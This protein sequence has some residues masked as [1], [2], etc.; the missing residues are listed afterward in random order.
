MSTAAAAVKLSL[1]GK[2]AAARAAKTAAA[3]KAAAA[4]PLTP[5]AKPP[6]KY[7]LKQ[8]PKAPASASRKSSRIAAATAAARKITG[9]EEENDEEEN[10]EEENGEETE[11]NEVE[12]LA[13]PG[14]GVSIT[15]SPT[16][17]ARAARA[18]ATTR[19]PAAAAPSSPTAAARA[20][21]AAATMRKPPAA[22]AAPSS[23]SAAAAA[24]PLETP[25]RAAPALNA[26]PA[27]PGPRAAAAAAE[28]VAESLV[29]EAAAAEDDKLEIFEKREDYYKYV[30]SRLGLGKKGAELFALLM[31][32]DS[33]HDFKGP[34]AQDNEYMKDGRKTS[35]CMDALAALFRSLIKDVYKSTTPLPEGTQSPTTSKDH[36]QVQNALR[37][38]YNINWSNFENQV[39]IY[40]EKD[41]LNTTLFG[42]PEG[43]I[44]TSVTYS[45]F[46]K[47]IP[48][49]S[50]VLLL[51]EDDKFK[52]SPPKDR[53]TNNATVGKSLLKWFF[54]KRDKSGDAVNKD[55]NMIN[56]KNSFAIGFSFDARTSV[57]KDL[58]RPL[59]DLS[60]I[61]VYQYITPQNFLDS[62]NTNME[63]LTFNDNP[64]FLGGDGTSRNKFMPSLKNEYNNFFTQGQANFSIA[65][66]GFEDDDTKYGWTSIVSESPV[67]LEVLYKDRKDNDKH[68]NG[69]SVK[70]L[71]KLLI[72]CN[73]ETNAAKRNN[74][75]KA[76]SQLDK[77][78]TMVDP[79]P[80]LQRFTDKQDLNKVIFDLKRFGD[81]EQANAVLYLNMKGIPTVFVT[82]DILSGVY[83]RIIGNPTIY[84]NPTSAGA[85]DEEDDDVD[86]GGERSMYCYRGIQ[87]DSDPL[88]AAQGQ[89]TAVINTINSILTKYT[90][91][92]NLTGGK[93]NLD[94][95]IKNIEEFYDKFKF[96]DSDEKV[97]KLYET[98]F[99]YK[100]KNI[101]YYVGKLKATF[102]KLYSVFVEGVH[103]IYTDETI[104]PPITGA[105]KVPE[106][107]REEFDIMYP[108]ETK[109]Q[110]DARFADKTQNK[111]IKKRVHDKA[112]LVNKGISLKADNFPSVESA[113]EFAN[114]LNEK[115]EVINTEIEDA[116]NFIQFFDIVTTTK[117][118]MVDGEKKIEMKV[119]VPDKLF[120]NA[121]S[122][123]DKC[124]LIQFDKSHITEPVRRAKGFDKDGDKRALQKTLKSDDLEGDILIFFEPLIQ[125]LF[126]LNNIMTKAE[127]TAAGGDAGKSTSDELMEK[128]ETLLNKR[129]TSTNDP[130]DKFIEL[131]S[132]LFEEE[133]TKVPLLA[134]GAMYG[135][136]RVDFEDPKESPIAKVFNTVVTAVLD[137]AAEVREMGTDAPT[138][139][140]IPEGIDVD[141]EEEEEEET[142]SPEPTT[143]A[144][145]E[146]VTSETLP[147]VV[148]PVTPETLP[149]GV[150]E[151]NTPERT[152][153]SVNI[154]P[155]SI[156]FGSQE[157]LNAIMKRVKEAAK[158]AKAAAA[159]PV[160]GITTNEKGQPVQQAESRG[161]MFPASQASAPA[162][163]AAGGAII[164]Q[165]GRGGDKYFS[166]YDDV[167]QLEMVKNVIANM[168]GFYKVYGEI[169]PPDT[170][171]DYEFTTESEG[172]KAAV[173]RLPADADAAAKEAARKAYLNGELKTTSAYVKRQIQLLEAAFEERESPDLTIGGYDIRMTNWWR[174]FIA[175]PFNIDA[176][177]ICAI[178]EFKRIMNEKSSGIGGGLSLDPA[179]QKAEVL[180]HFNEAATRHYTKVAINSRLEDISAILLC[181]YENY[182][183]VTATSSYKLLPDSNEA[184]VKIRKLLL[185]EIFLMKQIVEQ[186]DQYNSLVSH[187]EEEAAYKAE[188]DAV[189]LTIE[190][191]KEKFELFDQTKISEAASS[192]PAGTTNPIN[193]Y[194]ADKFMEIYSL[195]DSA[196]GKKRFIIS[197][198]AP[199]TADEM[200]VCGSAAAANAT[201]GGRR[202]THKITRT[203]RRKTHKRRA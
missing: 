13:A 61:H 36:K 18:A 125:N 169:A 1:T 59:N 159:N 51:S 128:L 120:K 83:S 4:V 27:S 119:D 106:Y 48:F 180:A 172:E 21:R 123:V 163:A 110:R 63:V 113:T 23:P 143:A 73:Q 69:P 7:T 158:A 122:I 100:I 76:V 200:A 179:T 70:F 149:T 40:L 15:K 98:I 124:K 155:K 81:H 94:N 137:T 78:Y 95:L 196:A 133:L 2:R 77:N 139:T 57:I 46:A 92:S 8:G 114:K 129:R 194:F 33:Y 99:Q 203:H 52:S 166:N 178:D 85:D 192:A 151:Q 87:F 189:Y 134:G 64:N 167:H 130:K 103:K 148:E 104:N 29:L 145:E 26:F 35:F 135:G 97:K 126:N 109:A 43:T 12:V 132:P 17:A 80:V 84:V 142:V 118:I 71:S 89:V 39:R 37:L 62:A 191:L 140:L 65:N 111:E 68:R 54:E 20:A 38:F 25:P 72:D 53:T 136:E 11:E 175:A 50:H 16:A 138:F 66:D 56:G 170:T 162:A 183:V 150:D 141:E 79:S 193:K 160:F 49:N 105:T 108:D 91:L 164:R 32:C 146:P 47:G 93:T 186:I 171:A 181:L 42:G 5:A 45:S 115:L 153:P 107:T 131:L 34:R 127:L 201:E 75:N 31:I 67:Q 154:P 102:A 173:S 174:S 168:R 44:E 117:E 96:A 198:L 156:E 185:K 195:F 199:P 152:P 9:E 101:L 24:A 144:V 88:V 176:G 184:A 82:G 112:T 60:K 41:S 188:S 182:S 202:R 187:F 190:A 86:G 19:K 157:S 177:N 161:S 6:K 58:I 197:E 147:N 90:Q 121:V 55:I 3:A 10:G 74:C 30:I 22:A 14:A 116:N 28:M 165:P